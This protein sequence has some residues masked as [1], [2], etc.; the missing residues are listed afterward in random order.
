MGTAGTSH[1][2]ARPWVEA[3][4]QLGTLQGMES[5]I[6]KTN[7][8]FKHRAKSRA[9]PPECSLGVSET[10]L[11]RKEV[12]KYGMPGVVQLQRCPW[13]QWETTFTHSKGNKPW[14]DR[15][16]LCVVTLH[17]EMFSQCPGGH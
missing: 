9:K 13:L 17:Q 10:V 8:S 16:T 14:C 15:G 3:G 12:W 6:R 5:G 4:I 1:L 7:A 11:I 2:H